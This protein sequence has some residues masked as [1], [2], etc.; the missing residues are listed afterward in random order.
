MDPVV[1]EIVQ[2]KLDELTALCVNHRA[3]RLELFGSATDPD[4]AAFDPDH[5]DLDFLVEFED[6]TPREHALSYIGLLSDLEALFNRPV[7]LVEPEA[8]G[9]DVTPA[10]LVRSHSSRPR[11]I[12][13]LRASRC[14]RRI[15]ASR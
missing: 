15:S 11:S 12:S 9:A 6:M 3:R 7:D 8:I 13:A 2:E 14:A 4:P 10:T 1:T 5:S